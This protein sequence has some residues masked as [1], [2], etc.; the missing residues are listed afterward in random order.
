MKKVGILGGTFDPPHLGHLMIAEEARE[1]LE[2]E[3]VWFIPSFTPPHKAD[4]GTTADDRMKMVNCAISNNPFFKLNTIEIDRT[5]KSYTIDTIK[6]LKEMHPDHNFY[7]IIGAD[8]VEYLPKWYQIEE[9]VNLVQF[10]GVKR[11]GSTLDTNYPVIIVDIPSVD[12][13]STDLRQR[14]KLNQQITYLT[15]ERVQAYIK[16]NHLYGN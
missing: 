16:E 7:F 12:I 11:A 5:G 10:V 1:K 2:L 4:L 9:L 3:E 8:M 15:T 13:S 14:V 6:R